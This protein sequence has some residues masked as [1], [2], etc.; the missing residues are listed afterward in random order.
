MNKLTNETLKLINTLPREKKVKVEAIVRR[1]VLAC[2]KNGFQPDNLER[3]FI[4]AVEMVELEERFPEPVRE[5]NRDWEPARHYDQYISP[6]A[7]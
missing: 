4:E 6:R 1:H 5:D 3:V 2:Q 7:A